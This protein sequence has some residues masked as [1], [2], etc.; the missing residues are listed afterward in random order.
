MPT[1]LTFQTRARAID[2]LGRGQIA[3]CPTAVTELW[4][5][6]YD[7]Y[8]RNV[9]LHVFAGKPEVAAILDDGCGMTKQDI[10]E[11]WLVIGTASKTEGQE[12]PEADRLGLSA[13][14]KLGEKGIGR[15][16]AGFLAPVTLLVTKKQQNDFVA[17]LVDWRLFENPNL[18][19]S[20]VGIPIE[21]FSSLD[22]LES[23]LPKMVKQCKANLDGGNV[24]GKSETKRVVA[25]WKAFAKEE[26]KQGAEATTESRIRLLEYSK[27]DVLSKLEHWA[28]TDDNEAAHGTAL[29]L[30]DLN[31][32]L[33]VWVDPKVDSEDAEAND[34]KEKLKFTLNGFVDPND[35]AI[36]NFQYLAEYHKPDRSSV[37]ID[38]SNNHLDSQWMET[39][40]HY[41]SGEISPKG[42]FSGRV[43]GFGKEQGETRFRLNVP[44]LVDSK[45]RSQIGGFSFE[46]A[47]V[48]QEEKNTSHEST[49]LAAIKRTQESFAGM[50]VY[51]DG[52]RVLPYGRPDSDFFELE[53]TR[54]KH[55]GRGFWA[56][57]RVFGRVRISRDGNYKLKD[58]AGREG[59]V[60]NE[61]KRLFK[62]V[63]VEVLKTLAK[64][65]FG[66][67]K[68]SIRET[69][70]ARVRAEKERGEKSRKN[71]RRTRRKAF[72]LSLKN[73]NKAI[74]KLHPD[75]E[76]LMVAN[77]KATK[78]KDEKLLLK[79]LESIERFKES[80]EEI[81]LP[82]LPKGLGDR[83]E[84][85][86]EA[87]DYL[88]EFEVTL[89]EL[90]AQAL[91]T[92]QEVKKSNPREIVD[93]FR[94]KELNSM[95]RQVKTQLRGI[96]DKASKLVSIWETRLNQKLTS[97][98]EDSD[99]VVEEVDEDVAWGIGEIQELAEQFS[100]MV[101]GHAVSVQRSIDLL[102][103]GNDIDSALAISDEGEQHANDRIQQL[104]LLAQSGIAVELIGHELE[105]MAQETESNFKR[106]PD[107]CK[108]STAYKRAFSGFASLVD[109]FRFLSP[110]SVASYR[111]RQ[112]ITGLDIAEFVNE[113][114]ARRFQISE[115]DFQVSK[116]FEK[117]SFTDLP[118]RIYPVFVNL[119]NNSLYWLK[120]SNKKKIRLDAKDGLVI[121]ADSGPGVD[122]DDI[123]SLFNMFFTKRPQG[124]GIGLYLA[125]SNLAVA[126]HQIRYATDK[127][128]TALSGANFII[129]FKGVVNE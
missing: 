20:D 77:E 25:A 31:R 14:P 27:L 69:E 108:S 121:V 101:V 63:V 51:R 102:L 33:S 18:M 100:S 129:E 89:P 117:I 53:V 112:E 36:Q 35:S 58:K 7:A 113:F 6:A 90:E 119:I 46:I 4:K 84:E 42:W 38:S 67:A 110:F 120:F 104:M 106:M 13:R 118:S 105:E 52:V 1:Q 43:R 49:E 19:I 86:R 60:D 50:L 37:I 88:E 45:G 111:S 115:V 82:T 75:F 26:R 126:R 93:E 40:E 114:F 12:I 95:E 3:D 123:E 41:V 107:N 39:L 71:V 65:Y 9:S 91:A 62:D 116:A 103:D 8:A 122:R 22:E 66:G 127:D 128:P 28:L 73:A 94:L 10:E 61:A 29:L 80:F 64:R 48:E 76:S 32:E 24:T 34:V 72:L 81:E 47:A 96:S 15:L 109:R 2:H 78:Q 54:G 79:V 57:R 59:L 30:I 56:H 44:G 16:S 11:K 124:R 98:N 99:A 87:R 68:T 97:F 23:L 83:E 55:A 92:L 85:Y 21:E 70:I 17:V 125:K 74:E 5:N